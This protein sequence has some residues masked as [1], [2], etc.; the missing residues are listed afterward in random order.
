MFKLIT[1][2]P[3]ASFSQ[4]HLDPKGSIYDNSRNMRFNEKIYSYFQNSQK[5][6]RKNIKVLDLGC[7]GG[8]QLE[9]F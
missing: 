6:D 5:K 3:V 4:D 1:D 9:T 8:G 7:S 2:F